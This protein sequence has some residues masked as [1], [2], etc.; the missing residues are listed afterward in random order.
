M[1]QFSGVLGWL[2]VR[3]VWRYMNTLVTQS[4]RLCRRKARL[5]AVGGTTNKYAGTAKRRGR[6]ESKNTALERGSAKAERKNE[7]TFDWREMTSTVRVLS[8]SP[9]ILSQ[10][11]HP[12]AGGKELCAQE[13]GAACIR[14]GFQYDLMAPGNKET[15][16]EDVPQWVSGTDWCMVRANRVS[17]EIFGKDDG[18][19]QPKLPGVPAPRKWSDAPS[20]V[21][22]AVKRHAYTVLYTSYPQLKSV[23]GAIGSVKKKVKAT[24]ATVHNGKTPMNAGVF[25]Y[26]IFTTDG[27]RQAAVKAGSVE[28]ERTLVIP[29]DVREEFI[30]RIRR[31]SGERAITFI[32]TFREGAAY[33]KGLDLLFDAL[34][35]IDLIGKAIHCNVIGTGPDLEQYKQLANDLG[36]NVTFWGRQG[37]DG[38][39]RVLDSTDWYV[40]PSRD[41]PFGI[42]YLEALSRGVK[43]VGVRNTIEEVSRL[44]GV[45]PGRAFSHEEHDAPA[46]ALAEALRDITSDDKNPDEEFEERKAIAESVQD[47]F[48]PGSQGSAYATLFAE[49]SRNVCDDRALQEKIDKART[50]SDDAGAY[51]NSIQIQEVGASK[52][53]AFVRV[54]S[55]DGVDHTSEH[56]AR[57]LRTATDD[58]VQCLDRIHHAMQKRAG[59]TAELASELL[60]F[61]RYDRVESI[62]DLYLQAAMLRGQLDVGV[63]QIS[64][65]DCVRSAEAQVLGKILTVNQESTAEARGEVDAAQ[66]RGGD[67]NDA[68]EFATLRTQGSLDGRLSIEAIADNYV[69]SMS[70]NETISAHA[71][72]GG[73]VW[74][75]TP[76][77]GSGVRRCREQIDD[78]DQRGVPIG[79]VVRP[80]LA[81]E[82]AETPWREFLPQSCT[83][84]DLGN[85]VTEGICSRASQMAKAL[86]PSVINCLNELKGELRRP[87]DRYC[88]DQIKKGISYTAI[89][90]YLYFAIAA[91][92]FVRAVPM[93]MIVY[94]EAFLRQWTLGLTAAARRNGHMVVGIAS[95]FLTAERVTNRF[96]SSERD[97]N[98]AM[99]TA[100]LYMVCDRHSEHVLK[101][102]GVEVVCAV[103]IDHP[104]ERLM[105]EV[106]GNGRREVRAD[107]PGTVSILVL[108]QLFEEQAEIID[109]VARGLEGAKE[110]ANI[111]VRPHPSYGLDADA[112]AVIE[113]CRERGVRIHLV[114]NESRL[115]DNVRDVEVVVSV[116]STATFEAMRWGKCIIWAPF[117]GINSCIYGEVMGRSGCP[118]W[119]APELVDEVKRAIDNADARQDGGQKSREFFNKEYDSRPVSERTVAD[120]LCETAHGVV[121][122]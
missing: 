99:G 50:A 89:R 18:K 5:P 19:A 60:G 54:V 115:V 110:D 9:A 104:K 71:R 118:C 20:V 45:N 59:L 96:L 65:Q 1:N 70:T 30:G 66:R 29:P 36:I 73:R 39:R 106:D 84:V 105:R 75:Y 4:M 87:E 69:A 38:I 88:V 40:M 94:K 10:H 80:N 53:R 37:P 6:T 22:R 34:S 67:K 78:L 98:K 8:M 81:K 85:L 3:R 63:D 51:G 93:G 28:L 109:L 90:R 62:Q 82:R 57:D 68:V 27:V 103:G 24:V 12:F 33:R 13:I 11:N 64:V 122:D 112:E 58:L 108:L 46:R 17:P 77:D 117:L 16:F 35:R 48:R 76:F 52:R 32:S 61:V 42:V 74:F 102:E 101:Q 83:V 116:G 56:A 119:T 23:R 41:E 7:I 47:R 14:R 43:V 31:N 120:V 95:H 15:W 107:L 49:L 44:C 113:S 92:I 26:L 111:L 91:E 86:R 121:F 72:S 21:A 2:R 79:V 55:R 114:P 100:S 97:A 25:D